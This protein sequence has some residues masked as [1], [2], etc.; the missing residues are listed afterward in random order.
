[1]V[2]EKPFLEVDAA[3]E[4]SV[5]VPEL[6]HDSA[7]ITWHGGVTPGRSI[8]LRQFYIARAD[9]DTAAT[10]NAQLAKGKNLL[11]TPGIYELGDPI[12]VTRPEHGGDGA[13]LCDAEAGEGHGG[14]DDRGCGWGD[15]RRV[16]I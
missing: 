3:G 12:R 6:R 13:G 5:R 2:R 15:H 4:Y 14:D 8:P 10:I 9:R 7:G 11:L 16:A 1:M